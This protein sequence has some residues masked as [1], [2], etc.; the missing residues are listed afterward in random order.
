MESETISTATTRPSTS[1]GQFK[2]GLIGRTKGRLSNMNRS[3][4]N[5]SNNSKKSNREVDSKKP[6]W[7]GLALRKRARPLSSV[8]E[9]ACIHVS[10]GV[11]TN[12]DP[13]RNYDRGSVSDKKL[14]E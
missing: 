5:A 3:S 8:Q 9:Q 13:K 12:K 7:G 14:T 4:T 10:S 2:Q 11:T 1:D 6:V